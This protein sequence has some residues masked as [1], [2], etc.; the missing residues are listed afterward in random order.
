MDDC[1]HQDNQTDEML[2]GYPA[3]TLATSPAP[4]VFLWRFERL[5]PLAIVPSMSSNPRSATSDK[6]NQGVLNSNQELA[7]LLI[8]SRLNHLSRSHST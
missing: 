4:S 2:R 7:R 8:E 3:I 6:C 5:V 1:S